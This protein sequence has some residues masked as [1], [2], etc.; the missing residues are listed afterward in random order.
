MVPVTEYERHPC[1]KKNKELS[2]IKNDISSIS[3]S[4]LGTIVFHVLLCATVI[5]IKK[6]GKD[7]KRKYLKK[8]LDSPD[9]PLIRN[10]L[11]I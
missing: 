11:V 9:F 6:A 3:M 10:G 2:V 1:L 7:H 4:K 5:P 8:S